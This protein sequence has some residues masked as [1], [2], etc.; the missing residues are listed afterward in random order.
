MITASFTRV[1]QR[2]AGHLCMHFLAIFQELSRVS[3]TYNQFNGRGDRRQASPSEPFTVTTT[4]PQVARLVIWSLGSGG[5]E[6]WAN[7]GRS[8]AAGCCA[9][10]RHAGSRHGLT[11]VLRPLKAR[12]RPTSMRCHPPQIINKGCVGTCPNSTRSA[13]SNHS[14]CATI[15]G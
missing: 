7:I 5:L 12:R 10:P 13:S 4:P 15:W 3:K 6:Q 8:V 11:G 1:L 14:G 9:G 2:C